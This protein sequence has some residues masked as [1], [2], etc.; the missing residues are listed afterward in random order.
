MSTLEELE[1]K[2][3]ELGDEIEKLKAEKENERWV[4]K[5]GD[6]YWYVANDGYIH[7][8][9]WAHFGIHRRRYLIGNVFK[10]EQEA[11]FRVGQLKVEAELRKFARPFDRDEENWV[12]N[13]DVDFNAIIVFRYHTVQCGNIHFASKEIAQKAIDTVG[14]DRIKK[15]YFGITE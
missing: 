14:A 8:T 5:V 9:E 4:P 15:Y 11:E 10:T 7:E 3:K 1:K 6:R 12:I 2:Y 13:Y